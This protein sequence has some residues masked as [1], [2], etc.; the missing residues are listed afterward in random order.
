MSEKAPL[1]KGPEHKQDTIDASVE[2]KNNLERLQKAAEN[3]AETDSLKAQLES[4]QSNAENQAISGA[5][6]NV[7]DTTVENGDGLFGTDKTLKADAYSRTLRKV[8][9]QLRAPE[10][11]FSR[12]VHNKAI[13]SVSNASAKTIARP[14]AFLGASFAAMVG[15]AVLLYM[16]KQYGFTYNYTVLI[17]LFAGGFVLGLLVELILKVL[18]KNKRTTSE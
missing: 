17:V 5:E 6:L 9:T 13:E 7:G 15:S 18:F 8:R 16:S 2:S 3:A 11:A 10:R 4:L 14:S 1:P 12:V